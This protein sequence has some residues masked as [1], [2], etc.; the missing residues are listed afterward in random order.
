[1]YRFHPQ[2]KRVVEIAQKGELGQVQ[3]IISSFCYNVPDPKDI[4][5]KAELGGG[6]LLD[7]GSYCVSVARL[8]MNDEPYLVNASARFGPGS[9]VDEVFTGVLRFPNGGLST[10]GCCLH[11]PREQ[12]Y[13]IIGTEASLTVPVPFAPGTDDRHIILHSG[14]QRGEE[15]DEII[16]IKGANHY[17]L[18]VENFAECIYRGL[19]PNISLEESRANIAVIVALMQSAQE[20]KKVEL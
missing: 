4:R 11:S 12:W 5:L 17:Q 18:M 9:D 16:T 8:L 1:M 2:T 3:F 6:V 20:E 19:K 10:F 15:K 7:V 13:K 14:W